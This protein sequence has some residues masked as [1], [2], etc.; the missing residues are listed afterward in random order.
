MTPGL[1]IGSGPGNKSTE[2][3]EGRGKMAWEISITDEGWQEIYAALQKMTKLQLLEAI[4]DDFV[5]QYCM[6]HPTFYHNMPHHIA[7]RLYRKMDRLNRYATHDV[8]VDT[9]F[10]MI[11]KNNTCDNGGWKYWIDRCGYHTVNLR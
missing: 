3:I 1:D 6:G 4:E 10:E 5:E 8:L 9:C 2:I 7:M 11:Q